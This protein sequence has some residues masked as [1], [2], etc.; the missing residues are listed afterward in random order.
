MIKRVLLFCDTLISKLVLSLRRFPEAI[1]FY[2]VAVSILIYMN[3]ITYNHETMNML[4]RIAMIFALGA[5]MFLCI[6]VL[7]E[8]KP[9]LGKRAKLLMYSGAIISL[10]LYYYF[11][12][13]DMNMV[14]VSRYIALS[15][16][17]YLIFTFIPHFYKKENYEL[18]LITL[19][20]RFFV[21]YL[22]SIVLFVGLA[23]I[24]FT[25]EQLFGIKITQ[26]RL[27]LDIWLVVA[28]IFAPAF[29]LADIPQQ[30]DKLYV[31]DY[32]KVLKV[33]LLY[34]VLPIIVAYTAVLYAFFI[35]I[36]LTK[37]WPKGIVSNLVL[38]YSI[39]STIVIFCIY[40]LRNKDRIVYYFIRIFPKFIIIPLVM[41]FIAMGIRI[42]AY[43][44]TENRY[45]VLVAGLW[46]AGC[47]IYYVSSKNIRNIILT[48]SLAIVMA[49]SV[50]GPW[51]S[52]SI[53]KYSQNSRFEK[54]LKQNDM[55]TDAGIIKPSQELSSDEKEELTSILYYFERNHKLSDLKFLPENFKMEYMAKVFGF[56]PFHGIG[57][58]YFSLHAMEGDELIDISDYDY[59]LDILPYMKMEGQSFEGNLNVSYSE[60]EHQL[61]ISSKGKL[62]YEKNVEDIARTV[63]EENEG[64]EVLKK[65]EMLF[66]DENENIKVL[67]VF[68]HINGREDDDRTIIEYIE[69]KLFIKEI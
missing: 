15:L 41:M 28:G 16:S 11:P 55:I 24:I 5:V 66:T 9:F 10:M 32:S 4:K 31:E 23:A 45:F 64:K 33:L 21:T 44:I 26:G 47:M 42:N 58:K 40:P 61:K 67:Y 35:K 22:Y 65:R 37:E 7:L 13:I 36:L 25:I 17:L 43:G 18:Y 3:H 34:I 19:F 56:E 50:I 12:L 14:S 39:I 52:Y 63:Y 51:S 59:Y 60:R 20:T 62:I 48:V 29:F 68:N 2:S 49:M 38:W 30:E 46:V 57:I 54:I 27:Y 6:R 69:F 1:C 8:R 53:S